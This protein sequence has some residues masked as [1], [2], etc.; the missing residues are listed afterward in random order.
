MDKY[1][2]E[3][4]TEKILELG[5]QFNPAIIQNNNPQIQT[6]EH[7]YTEPVT[8]MD[9]INDQPL[10]ETPPNDTPI[11]NGTNGTI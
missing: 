2:K 5:K 3:N 11:D 7:I 4:N 9:I 8:V 6:N 10:V 1:Y